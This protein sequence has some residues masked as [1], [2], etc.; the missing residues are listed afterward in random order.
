MNELRKA[1]IRKK[2]PEYK[3]PSQIINVVEKVLNFDKKQ[4][5]KDLKG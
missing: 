5:I 3:N 4:K 2:F 1:V